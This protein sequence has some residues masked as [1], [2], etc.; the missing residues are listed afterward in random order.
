MLECYWQLAAGSAG[1]RGKHA[2]S[3]RRHQ[4]AAWRAVQEVCHDQAGRDDRHQLQTADAHLPG[5]ATHH[6]RR[7]AGAV[8][9]APTACACSQRTLARPRA[10]AV[11]TQAGLRTD[12]SNYDPVPG[13]IAGAPR[14]TRRRSA[15]FLT[16]SLAS[17][18]RALFGRCPFGCCA[19]ERCLW[20][21]IRK[22]S[23]RTELPDVYDAD[24]GQPREVQGERQLRVRVAVLSLT[25]R[26]RRC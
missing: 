3:E 26:K 7:A 19:H 5:T 13:W 20:R 2:N 11:A 18:L 10:R 17:S 1:P 15:R 14:R 9:C 23:C 12:S 25:D 16:S 6:R 21:R 24:V 4:G 22:P 8:C